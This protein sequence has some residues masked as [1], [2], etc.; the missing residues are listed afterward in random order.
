MKRIYFIL[1]LLCTL[2]FP[3]QVSAQIYSTAE[4]ALQSA[5]HKSRQTIFVDPTPIPF[6]S[7]S[8]YIT[9]R[10]EETSAIHNLRFAN[11]TIQTAAST[12]KGGVLADDTGF[13]ST[14][15][16]Q[17]NTNDTEEDDDDHGWGPGTPDLPLHLD[18]DALLLLLSLGILYVLRLHRKHHSTQP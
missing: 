9:S 17:T 12:L 15:G 1:L 14:G 8:S 7:T 11:G 3:T 13:I 4:A 2:V 6:R 5:K 16:S 10:A 18:W